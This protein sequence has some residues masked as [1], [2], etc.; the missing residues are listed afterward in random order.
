[1]LIIS[2]G[3]LYGGIDL[4]MLG[5]DYGASRFLFGIA[6]IIILLLLFTLDGILWH[7]RGKEIVRMN[8][9]KLIIKKRGGLFRSQ[10]SINLFEIDEIFFEPYPSNFFSLS[11][12]FKSIGLRGGK[13]CVEYKG[14]HV[15]Y[16]G[17]S[18]SDEEAKECVE[19]MNAKLLEFSKQYLY[20][21]DLQKR[22]I[23]R[24]FGFPIMSFENIA[25]LIFY[26][27]FAIPL[28]MSLWFFILMQIYPA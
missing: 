18:I 20:P 16:I 15:V 22:K 9:E 25:T 23:K 8:N 21:R 3:F 4:I 28:I 10:K 17:Q 14:R 1:M 26:S 7:L 24:I 6:S 13:I 27:L 11:A 12:N 19:E 5:D 2:A